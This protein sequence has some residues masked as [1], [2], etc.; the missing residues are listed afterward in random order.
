MLKALLCSFCVFMDLRQ[1]KMHL[2]EVG[3]G[4]GQ[5]LPLETLAGV[6]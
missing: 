6:S 1:Q 3:G 2:Q 5:P 4:G